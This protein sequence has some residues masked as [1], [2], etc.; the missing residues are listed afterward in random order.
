MLISW[1]IHLQESTTTCLISASSK[2]NSP[3]PTSRK[4]MNSTLLSFL[5]SATNTCSLW[6]TNPISAKITS[7]KTCINSRKWIY[8]PQ[9]ST[10][11]PEWTLQSPIRCTTCWLNR[12]LRMGL[13]MRFICRQ[14]LKIMTVIQMLKGWKKLR[15]L[16]ERRLEYSLWKPNWAL[17]WWPES[18]S[19]LLS[20]K[21]IKIL[22]K[23][24]QIPDPTSTQSSSKV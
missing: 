16:T 17:F 10:P 22:T 15:R 4:N 20:N 23:D 6:A 14:I 2:A 1:I 13:M 11:Q 18:I 5:Q 7:L 24:S 9:I 12:L 21:L 3:T 8:R 19:G